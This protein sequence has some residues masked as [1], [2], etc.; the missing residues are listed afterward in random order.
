MIENALS[1]IIISQS[2]ERIQAEVDLSENPQSSLP[3]ISQKDKSENNLCSVAISSQ[4]SELS[5]INS[6]E[7][8]ENPG[9]SDSVPF[10]SNLSNQ[11][12][13]I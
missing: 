6:S 2:A 13:L 5:P 8:S 3:V 12:Y 10:D 4:S 7:L 9:P 1:E 11:T